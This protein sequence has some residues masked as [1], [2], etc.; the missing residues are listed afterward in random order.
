MEDN[1]RIKVETESITVRRLKSF[2]LAVFFFVIGLIIG[3]I[4]FDFDVYSWRFGFNWPR[5]GCICMEGCTNTTTYT[6]NER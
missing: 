1:F 4:L 2:L 5:E 6:P 3:G